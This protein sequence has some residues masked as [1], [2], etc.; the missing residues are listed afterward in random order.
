MMR[1]GSNGIGSRKASRMLR[2][3]FTAAALASLGCVALS[4]PSAK[5]PPPT[6]VKI[7]SVPPIQPSEVKIISTP[8]ASPA[9]VKIVSTPPDESARAMVRLTQWLVGAN[10]L[11]CAVTVWSSQKQSRD[12]RLRDRAAMEREIRRAAQK[13]L[14]L[15]IWLH[16]MALE[17]PALV[18][19]IHRLAVNTEVPEDLGRDV[20]F[21]LKNRQ[22][23]LS[24]ITD[25]S[26]EI[27][28]KHVLNFAGMS[29]KSARTLMGSVDL[30]DVE[31][32]SMR[33]EITSDRARFEREI[34]A[35]LQNITAMQAAELSRTKA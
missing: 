17:V 21:T 31:L 8:P 6:E 35:L 16:Q 4:A 12:L 18:D 11:L 29:D 9:E 34:S 14:S 15:S 13:N 24:E 2:R 32:E 19:R 1:A 5:P 33:D 7:I 28:S 23:R 22:K 10:V 20:G 25:V 3:S 27:V 26:L 30:N